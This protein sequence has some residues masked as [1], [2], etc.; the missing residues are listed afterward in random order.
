MLLSGKTVGE[1]AFHL[2][3]S[4]QPLLIKDDICESQ[5][6]W[7]FHNPPWFVPEETPTEKGAV[8]WKIWIGGWKGRSRQWLHAMCL[9]CFLAYR[10]QGQENRVDD[11][12]QCLPNNLTMTLNTIFISIG[13]PT[14]L[15]LVKNVTL[16]YEIVSHWKKKKAKSWIT[17]NKQ[18]KLELLVCKYKFNLVCI[19]KT[20]AQHSQLSFSIATRKCFVILSFQNSQIWGDLWRAAQGSWHFLQPAE[21]WSK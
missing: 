6:A 9:L 14:E 20:I 4:P 7:I 2:L 5:G 1:G 13:G 16:V 3:I 18:D 19:S 21:A 15:V 11:G 17:G 12:T 10:Y 8:S